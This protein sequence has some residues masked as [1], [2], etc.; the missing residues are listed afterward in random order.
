MTP[1]APILTGPST[2]APDERFDQA[3]KH[4]R[5]HN[6]AG[7]G[8]IYRTI[9]RENPGHVGAMQNLID[10]L[11]THEGRHLEAIPLAERLV[12]F[13]P[14][15]ADARHRLGWL[16][17]EYGLLDAARDAFRKAVS[18]SGGKAVWRWKH[19][20]FCPQFFATEND[21][22][23]YWTRLEQE[24]D[25]ALAERCMYDW[26]TLVHDGF[27]P[28]FHLPHLD[29]CCRGVKEKFARLFLPSIP[30]FER[31]DWKPRNKLR[32]GFLVTPGHEG[33]FL[34]LNTGLIEHLDPEKFEVFLLY[35]EPTASRFEGKFQRNDLVRLPYSQNFKQAVEQIRE[36]R[37]DAIYYWKVGADNWSFFLPMCRL[38]PVQCTSWGTH[39]TSGLS[40]M[41]YY[42][43]WDKAEISYAQDHYTER[44]VL[45]EDYPLFAPL[46]PDLPVASR[47][48]LQLPEA[49]AVYFCPHRPSKYHPC[50]DG[51]L[52]EILKRDTTGHIVLLLGKP[53]QM[54]KRFIDRMRDTIGEHFS[55]VIV[56]PQLDV[57]TYYRYLSASTVLL[58]SPI[59][60]GEITAVDGF[61][62]GVPCVS[63]SGELLV[64]RYATAFYDDFGI[65]GPAASSR[66]EYV[67]QAVRLALDANYHRVVSQ[68]IAEHCHRFFENTKTVH[69]WERFFEQAVKRGR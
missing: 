63:L 1:H 26:T 46:L 2:F 49:G 10:V 42:V 47:L 4:H 13:F 31:P 41:D 58:N 65:T 62:Y 27:C 57:A 19:L 32:V 18:L 29:K 6:L 50:F 40:T 53:S 35:Q 45:F 21:I 20:A 8:K 7:A 11:C 38:A 5:L 17:G 43:S 69:A 59:Y 9:L 67:E 56:L 51:Y 48:E 61:L 64:Q 55:R 68:K 12:S 66:E 16:Y 39:G 33:G 14:E 60:S 54:M 30:F 3:V 22:E 23:A 15:S 24:L 28:S 37:L 25:E 36:A 52:R 34:R 44:L